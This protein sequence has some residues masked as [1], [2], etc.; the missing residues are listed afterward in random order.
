MTRSRV[1]LRSVLLRSAL[2]R[3]TVLLLVAATVGCGLNPP[4][5][6][7]VD[8][9]VS[10]PL[11]EPEIR[12]LPS[13]PRPGDSPVEI[14]R[15][16]LG[17][18]AAAPESE[19]ALARG[20]LVPGTV[21]N[22]LAG[23]TVYDPASLTLE[24][25]PRTPAPPSAGASPDLVELRLRAAQLATVAADG[26]YLPVAGRI[27]L[28]FR[29][30]RSGR[31]WRVDRPPAGLALTP[32]D[33]TRSYRPVSRY[34]LAPDADVLVPDPL[35]VAG[36]RST[37]PGAAVRS[38]VAGP[39]GWLAPAVRSAIPPGLTPLGSVVVSEDGT[40][41]VD[42]DRAAFG[43]PADT[44]PLLVGQLAS[45]LGTVPG[46]E[47][48]RVQAEG[49]TYQ[50]RDPVVGASEPPGL[51]PAAAGPT[52][53]VGPDGALL[54]L[55]DAQPGGTATGVLGVP[56]GPT[57]LLAA[58][59]DPSG[60]SMLA[61]IQ[62][63]G[64][65]SRLLTGPLGALRPTPVQSERLIGPSWLPGRGVV[66]VA[67]AGATAPAGPPRLLLTTPAGEVVPLADLAPFGD[68]QDMAVSPDGTRIVL[69][70]A[71]PAG[72]GT[73]GGGSAV[74]VGRIGRKDGRPAVDGWFRWATGLDD[75]GHVSWSGQTSLVVTGRR[76]G[77]GP[78]LWRLA[79]DRLTD[80]E[81]IAL[82]GLPGVPTQ[83]SA[84]PGRD[85]LAIAGG[86]LWRLDGERWTRLADAQA[87]A[88]PQ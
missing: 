1:L 32:R 26:S 47:S 81:R 76:E 39:S 44:R 16:F 85:L 25:V 36:T 68:V 15:G 7:R 73:P 57:R 84:A 65:A 87:V 18:A 14:V 11:E 37:L 71:Q 80:P 66:V 69:R 86:G 21:W 83:V 31:E 67:G 20:F 6:V 10:G 23:A 5:G 34:L 17:A 72:A 49:R 4:D 60:S 35:Y 70:A 38:L 63:S 55:E 75:V 19:H 3:A 28:R 46:V 43:V 78:A 77:G 40:A 64:N 9:R 59:P 88:Q 61:V 82:E 8:R 74:W 2:L 33:L 51:S 24:Q 62:R 79:L 29:L 30:V 45:T 41:V 27:D 22:D 54:R 50:E 58:V 12:R 56:G 13:G 53:A 42:L 52:Y 48:V